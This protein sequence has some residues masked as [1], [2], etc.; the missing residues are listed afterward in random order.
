MHPNAQPNKVQSPASAKSVDTSR[1]T[2]NHANNHPAEASAINGHG[3]TPA[4]LANVKR[5]KFALTQL[6]N[7][8]RLVHQH[9]DDIRWCPAWKSWLVWNQHRW[10]VDTNGAI[11]RMAH[12]TIREM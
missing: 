4:R 9:G 5:V 1:G 6:G 8:E 10:R 11:D 3:Q 12:S 7:A 2:D